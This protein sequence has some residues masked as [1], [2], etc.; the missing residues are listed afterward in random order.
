MRWVSSANSRSDK[1]SW[2]SRLFFFCSSC[3]RGRPRHLGRSGAMHFLSDDG[4]DTPSPPNPET[5]RSCANENLPAPASLVKYRARCDPRVR[6]PDSD[7][8]GG[9]VLPHPEKLALSVRPANE[10]HFTNVR[11]SGRLAPRLTNSISSPMPRLMTMPEMAARQ[12]KLENLRR[13]ARWSP[14]ILRT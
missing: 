9:F 3:R 6:L 13:L 10:G 1:F 5:Q 8:I 14:R 11:S 12:L 2:A 7:L 4:V